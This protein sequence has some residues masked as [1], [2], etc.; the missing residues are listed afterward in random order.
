MNPTPDQPKVLTDEEIKQMAEVERD[1]QGDACYA[2]CDKGRLIATINVL[3]ARAERAE[4]ALS[5]INEIRNS[6]IGLQTV[7]WSEH[8]YPL[9]ASL[10]Q[11]GMAGMSHAE[12]KPKYATLLE[13]AEQ[14]ERD[15]DVLAVAVRAS[16][17]MLRAYGGL[18][19]A[20]FDHE[21]NQL[22]LGK[23]IS[24]AC[25]NR[26]VESADVSAAL[27]RAGEVRP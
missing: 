16:R 12:A 22:E 17:D 13:R 9:V 18:K 4:S 3:R 6:I 20:L 14:A 23:T 5:K 7:S 11:A 8:I 10:D 1:F 21:G 19:I 2:V 27:A 25:V 26:H 24:G 15:R